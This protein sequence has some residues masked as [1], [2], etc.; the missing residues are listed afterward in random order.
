MNENEEGG[1]VFFFLHFSTHAYIL[2]N[3]G[4]LSRYIGG[5]VLCVL[6]FRTLVAVLVTV[7]DVAIAIKIPAAV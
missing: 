2:Y 6:F 3:I 4:N 5:I 7:A 1:N